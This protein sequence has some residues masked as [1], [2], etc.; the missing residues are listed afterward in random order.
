M[1]GESGLD[2]P[3]LQ[4][5]APAPPLLEIP[6]AHPCDNVCRWSR[7]L[8]ERVAAHLPVDLSETSESAGRTMHG[9]LADLNMAAG[10]LLTCVLSALQQVTRCSREVLLACVRV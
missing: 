6:F 9:H 2:D 10:Q 3:C 4:A 1:Q 5:L 8:Q 7:K